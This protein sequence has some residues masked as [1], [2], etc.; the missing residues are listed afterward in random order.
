[1]PQDL[2]SLAMGSYWL[3]PDLFCWA[4]WLAPDSVLKPHPGQPY[5]LIQPSVNGT[6]MRLEPHVRTASYV[7]ILHI[8][9]LTQAS[10]FCKGG[11]TVTPKLR[12]ETQ[13][14]VRVTRPQ[15]VAERGSEPRQSSAPSSSRY[16]MLHYLTLVCGEMYKPAPLWT[17]LLVT[18]G[19]NWR[20][21][22]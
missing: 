6:N 10:Q 13:A 9:H 16:T 15:S 8:H 5:Q 3:N 22:L 7:L 4:L 17:F 18:Q 2:T 19:F 1:M 12:F 11:S 14:E 21:T 20:A